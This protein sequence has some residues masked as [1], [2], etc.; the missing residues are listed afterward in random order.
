MRHI[1]GLLVGVG[2]GA[3]ILFA[4]GIVNAQVSTTYDYYVGDTIKIADTINKAG[5]VPVKKIQ[6]VVTYDP[7]LVAY[8]KY[9]QGVISG[10]L[11]VTDNKTG[12]LT[13]A[14][15][16]G[17]DQSMAGLV[18]TYEFRAVKSGAAKFASSQA[19]QFT[20][21]SNQLNVTCLPEAGMFCA[22]GDVTAQKTISFSK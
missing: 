15:D 21:T 1:Q 3:I 4:A 6:Y 22:I 2:I 14:L 19:Y 7:A 13:V 11:T 5:S 18:A 17:S 20:S 12:Q 8:S 9:T 10:G 16:T